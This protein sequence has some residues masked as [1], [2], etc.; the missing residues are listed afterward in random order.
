MN[1]FL[2]EPIAH[3]DLF[4]PGI[5]FSCVY[6][7]EAVKTEDSYLTWMGQHEKNTRLPVGGPL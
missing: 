2:S 5:R 1:F 3:V 6:R 4:I 7:L